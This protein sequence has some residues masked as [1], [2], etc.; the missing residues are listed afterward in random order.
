MFPTQCL[1][2]ESLLTFKNPATRPNAVPII[3]KTPPATASSP[4]PIMSAIIPLLSDHYT[5]NAVVQD[6]CEERFGKIQTHE[7]QLVYKT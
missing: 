1:L 6:Q 7:T 4:I 3:P 5:N 2:F